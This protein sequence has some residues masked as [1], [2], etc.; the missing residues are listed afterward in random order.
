M[1]KQILSYIHTI[2]HKFLNINPC[3]GNKFT[4]NHLLRRTS[5][6]G[7]DILRFFLFC[8]H[9]RSRIESLH[10]LLPF[11]A[12]PGKLLHLLGCFDL[13]FVNKGKE[14]YFLIGRSGCH[15]H[16]EHHAWRRGMVI[17]SLVLEGIV[18]DDS[19][20]FLYFDSF[21]GDTEPSATFHHQG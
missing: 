9:F 3:I 12:L 10:F 13:P 19:L 8:L 21:V 2:G 11:A 7:F 17:A 16:D 4:I 14:F 20:P 6:F 1:R 15:V 5:K 18:E